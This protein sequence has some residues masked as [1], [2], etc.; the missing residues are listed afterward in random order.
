MNA[1]LLV[2]AGLVLAWCAVSGLAR[3]WP[4]TGPMVFT[5]AGMAG[6]TWAGWGGESHTMD[7][8]LLAELTLVLVLFT[9]AS[10]VMLNRLERDRGPPARLLLIGLPLAIAVGTALALL[11]FPG[12]GVF[13]A[14]ILA[15]VLAPTDAALGKAVIEDENVPERMRRTLNVESG[16]NDGLALPILLILVACAQG[17]TQGSTAYWLG[18]TALQVA[19]GAALGAAVGVGSGWLLGHAS[20]SHWVLETY[21][22]MAVIAV[23][24]GAFA[25]A[26]LVGA[27]GLIAA[28]V[29]GLAF[30]LLAPQV[31]SRLQVFGE[32]LGE[33]LTLMVFL[34]FGALF[35]LPA[36]E[37]A[38]PRDWLYAGASLVLVR[39]LAVV[40]SLTGSS[41]DGT[42]RVFAGWFG[43]RGLATI[44]YALLVMEQAEI[45][46][47]EHVVR[48][49][50]LTVLLSVA[51][52]G[53]SAAP[54][55][56][57][58]GALQAGGKAPSSSA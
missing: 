47:A 24:V 7:V 17:H 49:G 52:H 44:L 12:M 54:L 58:Y 28:F 50:M 30:G 2:I 46:G 21:Q 37:G 55:A 16:L 32:T 51:A 35:V 19:G 53:L 56:R 6:A 43:P 5:A 18:F 29:A 8:E 23:S 39:P 13:T 38:T 25:S 41:L 20:R 57:A 4:V 42:A 45:P 3:R 1:V 27:N 36:L 22:R 9:D 33:F 11:V 10:H 34:A 31:C 48:V 26:E 40:L 14:A 15:S